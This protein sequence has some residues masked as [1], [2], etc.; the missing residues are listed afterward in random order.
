MCYS[1]SSDDFQKAMNDLYESAYTVYW[2]SGTINCECNLGTYV[3]ILLD[4]N[5]QDAYAVNNINGVTKL[6]QCSTL[7]IQTAYGNYT[8]SVDDID[9]FLVYLDYFGDIEDE[10]S[11]SGVCNYEV[12]YYFSNTLNGRPEKECY[13]SIRDELLLG[14]MRGMGI[15]F[16]VSGIVLLIVIFVQYGLWCREEPQR[17]QQRQQ[18]QQPRR[19]KYVYAG[20][21]QPSQPRDFSKP[22]PSVPTS[23]V[24]GAN[25]YLNPGP[26]KITVMM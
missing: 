4:G 12:V 24:S 2:R 22:P 1:S 3:P 13:K 25:L 9:D 21:N 5:R 17:Q 16:V 14:E 19:H 8:V 20:T 11:C 7:S 18:Q 26:K 23:A 15:G 10:Y 6:Q